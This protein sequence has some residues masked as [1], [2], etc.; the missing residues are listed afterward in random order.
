MEI[1]NKYNVGDTIYV[2]I[3]KYGK[4]AD[5]LSEGV[6]I[7]KVKIVGIGAEQGDGKVTVRYR[8]SYKSEVV[9]ED[10]VWSTPE[11]VRESLRRRAQDRFDAIMAAIDRM[12][13]ICTA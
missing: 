7:T 5:Y 1:K 4:M 9:A 13:W 11:D 12:D 6:R 8:I 10:D 2:L 3:G